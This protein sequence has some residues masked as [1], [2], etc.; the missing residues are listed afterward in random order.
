LA[1]EQDTQKHPEHY[2]VRAR[3]I[4][5]GPAFKVNAPGTNGADGGMNGNV[6]AYQQYTHKRSD[7][8]LFDLARRKRM[9]PPD[10]V[11]TRAWEYW[12][13]MSG[14]WLLFGRLQKDGARQILLY[15]F[16]SHRSKTLARSSDSRV[17]LAPGQVNGNYAVWNWCSPSHR[18]KVVLYSISDGRKRV[19]SDSSFSQLA[20]SVAADG[21]VY[22]ARAGQGCGNNVE[23]VRHPPQGPATVLAPIQSGDGVNT[24]Y[25]YTRSDG[26][27]LLFFDQMSCGRLA[28]SDIWK[29]ANSGG[30]QHLSVSRDGNGNGTVVSE[31]A[32]IDCGSDCSH[33]FAPDTT[34]TLT[35]KPDQTSTVTGWGGDCSSGGT[36]Q[37]CTVTMDA[38]KTVTVTFTAKP[39]L[40]VAMK[41]TGSGAVTSD[42]AGIDCGTGGTGCTGSFDPGTQV[43]LTAN[44]KGMSFFTGWGGDCSSS[45]MN[46]VC[47]LVMDTTRSATADFSGVG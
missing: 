13:R 34:V 8:E 32:G 45:G 10:G 29:I 17:F 16:A 35:A 26:A 42:P 37:T 33:Y 25:V 43:K 2:D 47:T 30:A 11:N 24:T 23:V 3:R 41:G 7:I 27:T 21:T 5:G 22:F 18:C 6:L 36:S 44:S 14:G 28:G 9:S 15:S 38:A 39:V 46:T 4:A 31:A 19:V 20:P 12:P 40:T 1:W